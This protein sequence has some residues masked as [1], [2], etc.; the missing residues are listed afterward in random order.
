MPT[1]VYHARELS[2]GVLYDVLTQGVSDLPEVNFK[3]YK[4][5][6]LH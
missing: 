5:G 4:K 1:C 2:N 3:T 6:Y